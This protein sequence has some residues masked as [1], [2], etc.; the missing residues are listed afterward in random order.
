MKQAIDLGLINSGDVVIAVQG[1]TGGLG[2]SN[3]LRVHLFKILLTI[4]T[5]SLLVE[6]R[7]LVVWTGGRVETSISCGE[8]WTPYL[9][10]SMGSVLKSLLKN[11]F[12]SRQQGNH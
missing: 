4:D 1:W 8:R 7:K 2:H 9:R 10:T 11:L 3:T 12:Y 5:R 6:C